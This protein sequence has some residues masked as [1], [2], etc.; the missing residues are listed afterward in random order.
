MKPDFLPSPGLI[1]S[2]HR[3]RQ[4][5]VKAISFVETMASMRAGKADQAKSLDDFLVACRTAIASFIDVIVPTYLSGLITNTERSKL[6]ITGSEAFDDRFVPATSAFVT[7]PVRTISKVEVVGGKVHLTVTAPFVT[8][9]T[10]VAY[11]QPGT[12][13]LRDLSGN[14]VATF[15]AQAVTNQI[16]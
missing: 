13:Q 12:N 14:L 7:S 1:P 6:V 9:A 16:V 4:E 2:G 3:L 10:T 8:G 5:L 15:A 11:T